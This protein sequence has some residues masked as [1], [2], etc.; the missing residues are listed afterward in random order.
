MKKTRIVLL[1]FGLCAWRG[2]LDSDTDAGTIVGNPGDSLVV[3]APSEGVLYH[4]ASGHLNHIELV[5]CSGGEQIIDFDAE[6][7]LLAPPPVELPSG[8]YCELNLAWLDGIFVAGDGDDNNG[9]EAVLELH[10]VF[11]LGDFTLPEDGSTII[12]VGRPDWLSP[13]ALDMEP[14]VITFIDPPSIIHGDLVDV[15]AL[16]SAAFDD[17]DLDGILSDEERSEGLISAGEGR[18]DQPAAP[19]DTAQPPPDASVGGGSAGQSAWGLFAPFLL[20]GRRRR[21]ASVRKPGPDQG[22]RSRTPA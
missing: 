19:D 21:D 11:T 22:G 17:E 7:D 8:R 15:G 12:E 18:P 10:D 5:D 1:A 4:E 20:M 13:D 9:F 14:D 6:I 3:V 16:E 2:S